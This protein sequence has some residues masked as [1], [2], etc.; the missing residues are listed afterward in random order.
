[1]KNTKVALSIAYV[2]SEGNIVH[3]ADM[4]PLDETPV[5]SELPAMYA[6]EMNQGWFATHDVKVGDRVAGLP[7]P[8]AK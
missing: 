1:M 2:D 3:L 7:G 6:L 8:S 5:P 4:R